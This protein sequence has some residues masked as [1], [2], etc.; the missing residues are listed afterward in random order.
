MK[1]LQEKLKISVERF[2]S[3]KTGEGRLFTER[4]NEPPGTTSHG[5]AKKCGVKIRTEKCFVICM[6][7]LS[8]IPANI[9]TK[10]R[11]K[12]DP[13]DIIKSMKI[14]VSKLKTMRKHESR[15]FT[16]NAT[17]LQ[18]APSQS[19]ASRADIRIKTQKC[20][21]ILPKPSMLMRAVIVTRSL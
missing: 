11:N 3:M 21:V 1:T 6:K 17:K 19:Y 2:R 18:G 14:S 15:I 7:P 9:I 5:I 10:H 8:I 4:E 13:K 20:Y 16:E 12:L